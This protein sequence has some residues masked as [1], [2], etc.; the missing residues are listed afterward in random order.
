LVLQEF[1]VCLRVNSVFF[2]SKLSLLACLNQI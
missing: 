2:V 1:D